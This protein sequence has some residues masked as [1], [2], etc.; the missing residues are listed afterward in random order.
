VD[1]TSGPGYVQPPVKRRGLTG[2][3]YRIA[4]RA[5]RRRRRAWVRD[6]SPMNLHRMMFPAA[7]TAMDP[8][9]GR[10]GEFS[11]QVTPQALPSQWHAET[12]DPYAAPTVLGHGWT[13]LGFMSEEE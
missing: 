7:V 8:V 9:P 1:Y 10:P 2:K 6:G 12:P 5:W 3:R 4:R 11:V 13:D